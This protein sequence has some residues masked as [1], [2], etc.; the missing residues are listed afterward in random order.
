M[1]EFLEAINFK[2]NNLINNYYNKLIESSNKNFSLAFYELSLFHIT[3]SYNNKDYD[4]ARDYF[5]TCVSIINDSDIDFARSMNIELND[6]DDILFNDS[7]DE[8]FSGIQDLR[9]K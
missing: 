4:K 3:D 8:I 1:Q 5:N 2:K 6:L 9:F 7:L